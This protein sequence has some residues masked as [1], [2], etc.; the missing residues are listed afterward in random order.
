[1]GGKNTSVAAVKGLDQLSGLR[2]NTNTRPQLMTPA[3]TSCHCQH[4][5]SSYS[6][7]NLT[8]IQQMLTHTPP[9]RL[10]AF[11]ISLNT[12]EV[13]ETQEEMQ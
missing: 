4:S 9:K 6:S 7:F 3:K 12:Q 11:Q 2:Q 1:M 10:S 5:F 8:L 13:G